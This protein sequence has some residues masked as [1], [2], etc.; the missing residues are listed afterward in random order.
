[1]GLV[2]WGFKSIFNAT[3]TR[4]FVLVPHTGPPPD[5]RMVSQLTPPK[6]ARE[7]S[8]LVARAPRAALPPLRAPA[9]RRA[10]GLVVLRV[11]VRVQSH[12]GDK[13]TN[14]PIDG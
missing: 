12:A 2:K 8:T 13:I 1:M 14:L 10:P 4:Y 11:R 7:G 3:E 6:S 9:A 5:L